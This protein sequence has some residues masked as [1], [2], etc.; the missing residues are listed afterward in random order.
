MWQVKDM[1]ER[2]VTL[3]LFPQLCAS[4][5]K[6]ITTQKLLQNKEKRFESRFRVNINR[7]LEGS[8]EQREN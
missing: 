1:L 6:I 8:V 2:Q 7:K 4:E 5:I 3:L